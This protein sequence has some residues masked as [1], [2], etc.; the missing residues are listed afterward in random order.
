MLVI[1]NRSS[2]SVNAQ[3][4]LY[5]HQMTDVT[6]TTKRAERADSVANRDRILQAAREEF[7]AHGLD[8][9]V[10]DIAARAGVGVGTLYRHFENRDGLLTALI[11]AIEADMG[12]AVQSAMAAGDPGSIV[13]ELIRSM[14]EICHRNGALVDVL[15]S[16][17]GADMERVQSAFSDLFGGMLKHGIDLGAFR[18]DLDVSVATEVIRSFFAAGGPTALA[19]DRSHP[20]A[21]DA[22]ADFFLA[23]I[24]A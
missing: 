2:G 9:E 7:G 6:Q 14:S 20:E 23:A 18:Q 13:R 3:N 5:W 4:V 19:A 22:F 15:L 1:M 21:A 8:A 10:S 16:R 17:R 12:K 11:Q 24:T